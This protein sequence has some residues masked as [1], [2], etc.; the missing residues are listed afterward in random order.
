[1]LFTVCH[2]LIQTCATPLANTESAPVVSNLVGVESGLSLQIAH[3]SG[4]G[5]VI[6]TQPLTQDPG[7]F[8]KLFFRDAEINCSAVDDVK[9]R[10]GRR[11]RRR[12]R[13]RCRSRSRF[14]YRFRQ[15]DLV[16]RQRGKRL[17]R[18]RGVLPRLIRVTHGF[19]FLGGF[20]GFGSRNSF[21]FREF[22]QSRRFR[23]FPLGYRSYFVRIAAEQHQDQHH[24]DPEYDHFREKMDES[25]Q[26][27]ASSVLT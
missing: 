10:H 16:L 20:L 15:R 17:R 14:R 11:G 1:M 19:R 27:L 7:N 4:K 23:S 2:H 26:L 18:E 5:R 3:D 13:C 21:R 8:D 24:R 25:V 9:H 22:F 6:H 12:S